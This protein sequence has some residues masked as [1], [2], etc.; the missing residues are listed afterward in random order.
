MK[1]ERPVSPRSIQLNNELR[2]ESLAKIDKA[3]LDIFS[4]YGY[5]GTAMRQIVLATGLSNGLIYHYY[6]TKA[7]IFRHLVDFALDSTISG[8]QMVMSQQVPAWQRLEIFA[9]MLVANAFSGESARSFLIVLQ[10]MTQAKTIPGLQE[11]VQAKTDLY[12]E[13]L[14]PVIAEAQ[15][16][17]QA[18]PGDPRILSAGFF[19][20]L[21]GLSLFVLH[22]KGL[23]SQVSPAMLLSVLRQGDRP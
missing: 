7:D 23:E 20:F 2:K 14:A 8:M 5:H 17:G 22:G 4:Q 19:S 11:S 18:G 6:P 21:Q 9:G 3:A 10:A 16:D 13:I 15:R 1:K 12:F